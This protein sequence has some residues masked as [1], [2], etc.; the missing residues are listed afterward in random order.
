VNQ[1][2]R[3]IL[4]GRLIHDHLVFAFRRQRG[5]D[6]ASTMRPHGRRSDRDVRAV[7]GSPVAND[8]FDVTPAR[9]V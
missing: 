2:R 9:L 7:A 8:A 5:A 6:E 4:D 3:V 1:E